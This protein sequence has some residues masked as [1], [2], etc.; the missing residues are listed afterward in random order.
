MIGRK[1]QHMHIYVYMYINIYL[2]RERGREQEKNTSRVRGADEMTTN[3]NPLI[4]EKHDSKDQPTLNKS[5][6]QL[7][8]L[9]GILKSTHDIGV[10]KNILTLPLHQRLDKT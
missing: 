2:E 9:K 1:T 10:G 7:T 4:L 6:S 5:I 3:E 8:V